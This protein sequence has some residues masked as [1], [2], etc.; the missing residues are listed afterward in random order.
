MSEDNERQIE[1]TEGAGK[2]DP[3]LG[4]QKRI[5]ALTAE[6][7]AERSGT[8]ALKQLITEGAGKYRDSL[9]AIAADIPPSLVSG[10]TFEEIDISL[11]KAREVVETVK[12]R[13]KQPMDFRPPAGNQGRTSPDTSGLSAM[14][15]IKY[16]LREAR[17]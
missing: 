12:A 16:G 13:N 15:K 10:E 17:G 6:L 8:A 4:M 9:L 14:E 1:D 7:E 5:D 3:A 2:E 11:A